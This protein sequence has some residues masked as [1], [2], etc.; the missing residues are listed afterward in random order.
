MLIEKLL[1]LVNIFEVFFNAFL[2]DGVLRNHPG[3][4]NSKLQVKFNI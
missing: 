2:S 1:N 3:L 4:T